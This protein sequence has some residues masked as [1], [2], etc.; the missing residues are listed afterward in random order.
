MHLI[1]M[2]RRVNMVSHPILHSVAIKFRLVKSSS[3]SDSQIP[4]LAIKYT[5]TYEFN[6]HN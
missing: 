5:T 1:I 2:S 3:D 4:I 6:D